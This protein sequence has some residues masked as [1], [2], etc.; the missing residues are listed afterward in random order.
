MHLSAGLKTGFLPVFF[1][2]YALYEQHQRRPRNGFGGA[3]RPVAGQVESALFQPLVVEYKSTLFP[4]QQL[5]GVLSGANEEKYIARHRVLT[6]HITNKA[7]EPIK[8]FA[9]VG[10]LA[11]KEKPIGGSDREHGRSMF[12]NNDRIEHLIRFNQKQRIES[13][14]HILVLELVDD[15]FKLGYLNAMLKTK[16][17][18]RK[19]TSIE[20][21]DQSRQ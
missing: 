2:P 12:W 11:V 7:A 19:A 5:D 16:S 18:N 15:L 1:Y 9:H 3:V 14:C 17:G 13:P 4:V 20:L 8:A 6:H 10:R 21:L